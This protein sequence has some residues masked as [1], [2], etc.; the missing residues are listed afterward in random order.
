MEW[1]EYSGEYPGEEKG[2]SKKNDS[3]AVC[4]IQYEKCFLFCFDLLKV[5]YL[6]SSTDFILNGIIW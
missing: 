5:E 2:N 6:Y 1:E 4:H 3:E